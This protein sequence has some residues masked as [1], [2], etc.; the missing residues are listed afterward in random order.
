M[1]RTHLLTALASFGTGVLVGA[2]LWLALVIVA[3]AV[4][5]WHWLGPP[6]PNRILRR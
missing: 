3:A 2:Q 4:V 6:P 1:N 5:A